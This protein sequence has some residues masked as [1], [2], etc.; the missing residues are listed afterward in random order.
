MAA[1]VAPPPLTGADVKRR[2]QALGWSQQRLADALG[3]A[4]ISI[5]RWET[6][7][8]IQTPRL[9]DL[10]LR[11]VEQDQRAAAGMARRD[12]AGNAWTA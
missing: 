11:W 6:G 7:G 4:R 12:G 1:T 10:A 3:V 2:R 9:V 8:A 5:A